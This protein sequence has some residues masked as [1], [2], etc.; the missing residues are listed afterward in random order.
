MKAVG[1]HGFSER[2]DELVEQISHQ[3]RLPLEMGVFH[4]TL[5]SIINKIPNE[6]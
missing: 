2:V 6:H 5:S 1:V 4:S 3:F